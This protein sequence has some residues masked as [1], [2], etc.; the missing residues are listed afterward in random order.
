M[1]ISETKIQKHI[2]DALYKLGWLVLRNHAQGVKYT[3][4]RGKNP[5]AGIPDLL[6]VKESKYVWIEVKTPKGKLSK[7]QEDMHLK[8]RFHGATVLVATSV[9]DIIDSFI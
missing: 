1:L 5:S 8:L 2:I 4:G 7:S 3:G 6:A 9:E